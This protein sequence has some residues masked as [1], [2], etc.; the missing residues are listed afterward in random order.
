MIRRSETKFFLPL[1][2]VRALLLLTWMTACFDLPGQ[3]QLKV[4]GLP[5]TTPPNTPIFVMGEFNNWVPNDPEFKMNQLSKSEYSLTLFIPPGIYEY[6]YT[7]GSNTSVEGTRVD[8]RL[9]KP[10][11]LQV[12]S[13]TTQTIHDE[14][15]GWE[16]G[17]GYL[18]KGRDLVFD[19]SEGNIPISN[20]TVN[21]GL[22]QNRIR[23]LAQDKNGFI[24]IGTQ[25]A[26][27]NRFDGYEFLSFTYYED[28]T[29]IADNEILS[30]EIDSANNLL[31]VGT[32]KGLNSLD[33]DNGRIETFFQGDTALPVLEIRDIVVDHGFLWLATNKGLTRLDPV[34][35]S[36][37]DFPIPA[38]EDDYGACNLLTCLAFVEE[39]IYVGSEVGLHIFNP[40][41]GA[42]T[43]LWSD[44]TH[45]S[46]LSLNIT[47]LYP[48]DEGTV[49]IGTYFGIFK[50]TGKDGK[51]S[52][53][54]WDELP[55]KWKRHPIHDIVQ[56]RSGLFWLGFNVHYDYGEVP[57]IVQYDPHSGAFRQFG[58][59][60]SLQLGGY[61]I[62]DILEDRQG[63][64]WFASRAKG[65]N[66]LN[67]QK[68]AFQHYNKTQD[69]SFSLSSDNLFDVE[70]GSDHKVWV[71]SLH[72]LN[73]WDP[74]SNSIQ[75]Y[76]YDLEDPTSLSSADIRCLLEDRQG[77]I[78]AGT[79]RGLHRYRSATNDFEI[80]NPGQKRNYHSDGIIHDLEEDQDGNIWFT[81]NPGGR[82]TLLQYLVRNNELKQ[83]EV[84]VDG[85]S[86]FPFAIGN[87]TVG[88]D[89]HIFIGS[90][91]G[92]LVFDAVTRLF[93]HL[94]VTGDHEELNNADINQL[95]W[96]DG[97]LWISTKG[98]G[99][100]QYAFD[101]QNQEGSSIRNWLKSSHVGAF[102]IDK[103]G[104]IWLA[105]N[106]GI[107]IL[108]P[109]LNSIKSY[110]QKDGI[111]MKWSVSSGSDKNNTTG[112]LYFVS[113]DGLLVFNPA[114][115]PQNN[116]RPPLSFTSLTFFD[117]GAKEHSSTRYFIPAGS[118]IQLNH[119]NRSFTCSFVAH[120]YDQTQDNQYAYRIDRED[121][122]WIQIGHQNTLNFSNLPYGNH[123]LQ[124][125]GSN[126][127]G[128]WNE[129][130][131][132]LHLEILPPWWWSL[133]AKWI[134][135]LLILG[136]IYSVVATI[137]ARN[138]AKTEMH[139]QK[140][141]ARRNA[142]MEQM[143][144]RFY[145][146][147]THEFRTPLTVIMGMNENITGHGKEK[148]LIRRNSQHLL[149]LVNELL[150]ISKMDTGRLSP[151][152][153]QADL[154]SYLRYLTESF[155]SL[156][157]EKKIRLVF[158]AEEEE[159]RMD[160]DPQK[161]QQI[162]YNLLSN[163]IR[164]TAEGGQIIFSLN[165]YDDSDQ[166][167]TRWRIK[168]NGS[169]IS[170]AELP[171]IFDRFYQADTA[172]S[173]QTGGTGIGL[174]LTKQLVELM[175]GT[176]EVNSHPGKGTEFILRFPVRKNAKI[177]ENLV[178]SRTFE[179]APESAATPMTP[180]H[181]DAPQILIV[182]D[183]R[184]VISYIESILRKDYVLN[185]ARDG[186]EG[187]LR[188]IS[189]LPDLVISDVM[190]PKM[191]GYD[192][193]S[194]IKSDERSSHIP[195]ILLTAKAM[196]AEKIEGLKAGADA[197][198]V[199]PFDQHEL[200]I[201]IEQLIS[202]RKN[203]QQRY[204]SD[205]LY[206]NFKVS[207]SS[208]FTDRED[209][210][211]YRLKRIIETSL[212][213]ESF[214]PDQ[215]AEMA[216]LTPTQLYRKTKALTDL[217]PKQ[218]IRTVRLSKARELLENSDL[219]VADI[220]YQVGFTDPNYFSRIFQKE[221]DCTPSSVRNGL[222]VNEK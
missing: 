81:M 150:D 40:T 42:F 221:F 138:R 87:I 106:Q 105:T 206:G 103:T 149:H 142:E 79:P 179:S 3:V 53:E 212:P 158:D 115:I 35:R 168:D 217:T 170:E 49:W 78:W 41:T 60:N 104:N 85:N 192:L 218:F 155:Y 7:R 86:E 204:S 27:L 156:A 69:R 191:N 178:D 194:R 25:M 183:N 74:Q 6:K 220:A 67:P 114:D 54:E 185:T 70:I 140:E 125:I 75:Y 172:R 186:E 2:L 169:G 132:Q 73:K 110:D 22:N 109:V 37:Q 101:G 157:G 100:Y 66:R 164:Y 102:E 98:N 154:V 163:A 33:L 180:D 26:G 8:D 161:V 145:T 23:C 216:D 95:Q 34:S 36:H 19:A 15:W 47:T 61:V 141:Q 123:L 165:T 30:L 148:E 51:Y 177:I 131:I 45:S 213:D 200:R 13:N 124:I 207:S 118:T 56:D 215:L 62:Y 82:G 99:L 29:G 108:D 92:I 46:H 202:I 210:F 72:G 107:S 205:K 14:I 112:D 68:Q 121:D 11:R 151:S 111:P 160:F 201:R 116:Y 65:L 20:W 134:Y 166:I 88:R 48:D 174:A 117:R 1:D 135:V 93:H 18:V 113:A 209:G 189:E 28:G 44:E 147:I 38:G 91:G 167:W 90:S 173:D 196:Q 162:I 208:E 76:F 143:K 133:G 203:L 43:D 171:F 96:L 144:N 190:M 222:N 58:R 128:V 24:W 77:N 126:N 214:S 197:Y 57:G 9:K 4:V 136:I 55:E 127:D 16:D 59:S 32:S 10:R 199:K 129:E 21:D 17:G 5:A 31:W 181:L 188:T 122:A 119:Q 52:I 39:Q 120:N 139:L 152:Y 195:V 187:L 159:I 182:E 80:I 12:S 97:Y 175:D 198:L 64:I 89:N 153:I 176:I 137:L 184:D 211:V 63:L 193:C 71:A 146:N 50:L 84:R 83:F 219:P 94:P 130:G